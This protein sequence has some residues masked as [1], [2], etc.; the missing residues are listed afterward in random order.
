VD[1]RYLKETRLAGEESQILLFSPEGKDLPV[2][3]LQRSGCGFYLGCLNLCPLGE[4]YLAAGAP[5][6]NQ[7]DRIVFPGLVG[8]LQVLL[9]AG[10]A[11]GGDVIATARE[12][13]S[14]AVVTGRRRWSWAKARCRTALPL[15]PA[16][17]LGPASYL[18]LPSGTARGAQREPLHDP[19]RDRSPVFGPGRSAHRGLGAPA[20]ARATRTWRPGT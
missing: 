3:A 17:V 13:A 2:N 4:G 9:A 7:G 5:K 11:M 1:E 10:R 20:T 16:G 19:G 14:S 12:T 6:R 15:A 18:V 8:V